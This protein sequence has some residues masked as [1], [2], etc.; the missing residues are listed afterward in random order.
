[1]ELAVNGSEEFAVNVSVYLRRGNVSMSEHF[2]H[3]PE[4]SATLQQ[5]SGE[6]MPESVR[7]NRLLD[8]RK[9]DVFSQNL[10]RTHSRKRLSARVEKENSLPLPF[11]ELWPQL[12]QVNGDRS[13]RF[14]PNRNEAFFRSLSENAHQ[15]IV[16]Q[17]ITCTQG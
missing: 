1:M 4:V 13:D 14:P 7:R 9:L 5:V 11:L 12:S 15:M 10:P 8:S 3:R 17:H 6:L 16:H 2:L